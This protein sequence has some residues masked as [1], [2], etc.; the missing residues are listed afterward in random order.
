M[1]FGDRMI[2]KKQLGKMQLETLRQAKIG[3][4]CPD[5]IFHDITYE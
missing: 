3:I 1:P 2:G 4:L 5:M